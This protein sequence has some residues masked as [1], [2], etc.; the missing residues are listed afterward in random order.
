MLLDIA[1]DD[2]TLLESTSESADM[3]NTYEV[4]L[5][6]NIRVGAERFRCTETTTNLYRAS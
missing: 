3:E 5:G 1:L 2:D 6:N 4:L